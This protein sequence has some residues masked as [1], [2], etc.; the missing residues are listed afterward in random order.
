MLYY[1]VVWLN[2]PL[3]EVRVSATYTTSSSYRRTTGRCSASY[4]IL[5]RLTPL[6]ATP[7]IQKPEGYF[8]DIKEAGRVDD[9][10]ASLSGN[11][12]IDYIVVSDG[13]Q[14]WQ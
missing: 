2:L 8:L 7:A 1:E 5:P 4:T 14:V 9:C 6:Q 13:E 11:D 12:E 10:L 3:P